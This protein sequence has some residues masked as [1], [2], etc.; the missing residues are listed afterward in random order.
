MDDT[1]FGWIHISDIHFGHGDTSHGW[2]QTLVMAALRRDIASKP[3]PVRVD[4]IFVTGDIAFSGAGR[5]AREYE[6][7]RAW[8]LE[9]GTA[10]GVN[11]AR[12][13]LVPGNHDVNRN[14]DSENKSTGRLLKSLR[15]RGT[16]EASLDDAL[17]DTDDCKLLASRMEGYL[18]LAKHFGPWVG[19]DPLPSPPERLYWVHEIDGREGLRVRVLGLNTAL[20]SRDDEDPG[21]LRLGKEQLARALAGDRAPNELILALSHHPLRRGWLGDEGN[22]DAWIRNNAHVHLS[23]HVH[24]AES[25][26]ARSGA[27]GSFVR[28][29][30]G[31]AH[32]EQ[33]PAWIP[34]NHGYNFGEVRRGERGS[35]VLCVYP[36]LWSSGKTRF[37]L[38]VH[39]VP[40]GPTQKTFAE[41]ELPIT[42]PVT[43]EESPRP[44]A[45]NQAPVDSRGNVV[46]PATA[47][48]GARTVEPGGALRIFF[49]YAPED[50]LLRKKLE[51]A[52]TMLKRS[53]LIE[54]FSGRS[55]GAGEAWRGVVG[56][57]MREARILLLLLSNDYLASDYCY[58]VEMDL[59]RQR[60]EAGDAVVIPVVLREV[61]LSKVD[62]LK[63]N[64]L[65]FE[66]LRRVPV[67]EGKEHGTPVTSWPNEDAAWKAVSEEIRSAVVKL[68]GTKR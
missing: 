22:A 39:S 27:G 36:R 10:A 37:V 46:T 33:F 43:M 44:P 56:Q 29:T 61:D 68:R 1:L 64:E 48:A 41:H 40:D 18:D 24:E 65:W 32:N 16:P 3:V 54:S 19:R 42:L 49:S 66:K 57:Q 4:A 25:E 26:D 9:A 34:A 60:Y 47:A 55:V 52:M 50:T 59:A 30:A 51:N 38:D 8:L 23:G 14:A 7:A 45:K 2:D 12:I 62:D 15:S 5:S 67:M 58:D 53:G 63:R 35:V 13:F 17:R 11:P 28:V 31:A 6:D 21:Q 20:L